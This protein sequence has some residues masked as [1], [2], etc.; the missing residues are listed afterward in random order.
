MRR[1]LGLAI[2]LAVVLAANGVAT[3]DHRRAVAW[4]PVNQ[5]SMPLAGGSTSSESTESSSTDGTSDVVGTVEAQPVAVR[6]LEYRSTRRSMTMRH[7]GAAYMKVHFSRLRLRPGDEVTVS[8]PDNAQR[9]AYR[10]GTGEWAMSVDG[11]T[12]IVTMHT[13]HAD[14]ADTTGLGVEVDRVARGLTATELKSRARAGTRRAAEARTALAHAEGREE[15]ICGQDEKLDAVCYRSTDP[16]VYSRSKA[17][18]RLLIGGV[19]LCSAWRVGTNNRMLT[20]HHC[21]ADQKTAATAEVWFNYQCS[22]C[23]GHDV[24]PATKVPVDQIVA[25]GDRLDYTMFSVKNFNSIKRFGYLRPDIRA[26]RAGE[27]LYIPQ[28]PGGNP[29][30]IAI[31]QPESREGNCQVDDPSYHGYSDGTDLSYYCDT[32]GGS[33]GS[34]VL[35]RDTNKVIGLHHFGGCHNSAVRIDLIYQELAAAF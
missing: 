33:S 19:E 26:P 22:V 35:S 18:A 2:G 34:P 31:D 1:V 11:D 10:P 25:T 6:K 32:E 4:A 5:G 9:H 15:S 21:I 8:G 13:R 20:N 14:D 16:V 27:K 7:A 12:A 23:G 29:T 30:K 28:H 17:V 3:A 24:Q